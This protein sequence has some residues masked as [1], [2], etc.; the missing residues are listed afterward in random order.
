MDYLM[1]SEEEA[2]RLE[3]KTDA[4]VVEQQ[5]RWGGLL[6]GMRL[7]DVGCGPGKT[8]SVLHALVQPGGTAVGV[9]GSAER[10]GYARKHF[11]AAG[12]EFV[13][14]DIL[15]P[16]DDL[17]AFDFVWVRFFL[18]YYRSNA[19]ELVRN[20]AERVKPGGILCLIDLDY[21][22]LSHY[23]LPPRLEKTVVAIV[24]TLEEK[25]NF[26]PYMGRKLYSF[27]YDL[28]FEEIEVSVAAHHLI[29]GAL[30]EVDAFNWLKKIEIA[31]KRIR[32]AF[33]EYDGGY[34]EFREEFD[35]F[36][37]NPRRFTYTPVI[38]CRGRRPAC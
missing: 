24:K 18:E 21:N 17:G 26:D 6:P 37:S 10:I 27:L 14:K 9:D 22:C 11:G 23:G 15:K 32:F 38:A 2:F 19:F 1:E 25:A 7:A 30:R 3:A 35:R 31:P 13:Q 4:R 28:G 5:A 36:F 29:Y 16:L 20:I 34:G 8:T 33:D 12:L